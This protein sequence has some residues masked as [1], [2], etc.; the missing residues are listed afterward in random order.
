MNFASIAQRYLPRYKT[1]HGRSTTTDQWSAL[2]AILGCRTDQYGEVMLSCTTCPW[3]STRYQ[4]CGHRSCNQCQNHS[5]TQWLE[6]QQAKLLPIDYFMVTFTLPYELRTLAKANQKILYSLLFQCAIATLKDF[7]LNDKNLA[8]ELAATAILHTHTR[9]LDYHPHIHMIVP[10]GGINQQRNEWRKLKGKYLFNGF[11]LAKVFRGRLLAAIAEVGL[12]YYKT[13]KKWV[14]HCERVGK[15][16]PALKYLSR[17][18]YRG[19][20]SDKNILSDDGTV[21]TFQYKDSETGTM[22]MRSCLGED[23]I[24]MVLQHTLPKGFRRTR[25][26]GFLHG[27]AKRILKIVQWVLQVAVPA[28]QET[29]RPPFICKRCHSPMAIVGFKR[30]VRISG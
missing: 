10:G 6:R 23:F 28:V 13:P 3:Q 12:G 19:V 27:N 7:G 22:E 5:T 24:A 29:V 20:I 30:P 16:L 1:R 9:R 14:V 21:V 8:A 15:G 2:N 26:Y 25:D 18:L 11:K 17:Y 4:S